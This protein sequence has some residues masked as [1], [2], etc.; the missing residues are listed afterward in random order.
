[1]ATTRSNFL[2]IPEEFSSYDTSR[3]ALLSIPFDKACSWLR[4][5]SRGPAAV[6]EASTQLELFDIE[7]GQEVFK[8]GFFTAPPVE[9][10]SSEEMVR[11]GYEATKRLLA[12][13]KFV[14]TVGGDHS[15]SNGPIRAHYEAYNDISILHIDAH[16]DLRDEYEG[17]PLS[18][19]SIIARVKEM[20]GR[21][22]SVGIR[23]MDR[24]E[25][26]KLPDDQVFYAHTLRNAD[27]WIPR[28]LRQ[29]GEKVYVTLDVDAFDISI[30]PST[31]TPEPGGLQWYDVLRLLREVASQ[32]TLVGMDVVELLPSEHT[33]AP[34]FLVA[35]LIYKVAAYRELARS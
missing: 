31:G 22:V 34:D 7:T 30:M 26:R 25:W 33:K 20:T 9:A 1:M 28:V 19:A 24:S 15:I 18:H 5:A 17:T 32:H 35:K 29:L 2:G 16:S 6:I 21:I 4:G 13:G 12:D 27:E 14:F 11:K 10:E 8:A 23:S 3:Y